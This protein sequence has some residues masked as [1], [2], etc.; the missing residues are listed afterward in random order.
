V[1]IPASFFKPTKILLGSLSG[2][3]SPANCQKE[4]SITEVHQA[5]REGLF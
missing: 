3:K 5:H 1:T 2:C 4:N